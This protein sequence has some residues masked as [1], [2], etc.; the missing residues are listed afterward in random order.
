[1]RYRT[2]KHIFSAIC[3]TLIL[4]ITMLTAFVQLGLLSEMSTWKYRTIRQTPILMT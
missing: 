2:M 3:M 4:M 1:M